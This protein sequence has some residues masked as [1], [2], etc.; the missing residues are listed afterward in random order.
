MKAKLTQLGPEA[1]QLPGFLLPVRVALL[2]DAGTLSTWESMGR[3]QSGMMIDPL[4]LKTASPRGLQVVR[5]TLSVADES[6]EAVEEVFMGIYH[7]PGTRGD[8]LGAGSG[9]W[10]RHVDLTDALNTPLL[11]VSR[12]AGLRTGAE[13]MRFDSAGTSKGRKMVEKEEEKDEQNEPSTANGP[14]I[15]C[16]LFVRAALPVCW[17]SRLSAGLPAQAAAVT[18]AFQSP[19]FRRRFQFPVFWIQSPMSQSPVFRIQSPMSQSPVFR[20]QSPMSQSPVFRI[21][22]LRFQ[23]PKFEC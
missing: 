22:S 11:A 23:S 21:Q 4:W 6:V 10:W 5:R 14:S 17:S 16:G 7:S 1:I 18:A 19:A 2:M 12:S 13:Q 15:E 8:K 9:V 3:M 20:I